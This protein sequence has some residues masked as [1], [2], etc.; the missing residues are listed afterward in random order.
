MWGVELTVMATMIAVNSIFAGY[1]IALASVSLARLQLL[2]REGR[3]GATASLYMK[4]NMEGSLATV[5]LG[6]TLFGAVAAATGGAGAEEQL[7]PAKTVRRSVPRV[8]PKP[9]F[10][11][12]AYA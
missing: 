4:E 1:E 12:V 2:V 8:R 11:R 9:A 6:I 7:A 10:R 5:Q 3:R